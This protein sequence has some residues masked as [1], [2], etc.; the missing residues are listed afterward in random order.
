MYP[1]KSTFRWD[2]SDYAKHSQGQY[3][4][5]MGNIGKLAL[6]GSESVLDI[7]CGDGKI[8]AEIAKRVP[9]G[10]VL[11]I[12]LSQEMIAL[13]A[14]LIQLPHVRFQVLDA[15]ELHFDSEFDAVFSNSALHWMPDHAAVV[16]GMAR[17][18]KPGGRI[19][20]S[21]GGRGTAAS[22][23]KALDAMARD[24]RWSMFLAGGE[25]PF[26]FPGPEEYEPWLANAG[27]RA[28]RI[29]LV[30]KP[31]RHA[32]AAALEGWFRTT[33]MAYSGRVPE[34]QRAEFVRELADRARQDCTI[35]E[36]GALLMPMVNLEV[37]AHKESS[38]VA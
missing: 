25:S 27:I 4:W 5:A 35:A 10:R 34:N 31:M 13:A 6:Q 11:G 38:S 29:E 20:L 1:P 14:R 37:E 17:A 22:G 12:D 33:W 8:T 36:D 2:A 30:P 19:F 3:G 16:R 15:Q 32:D 26:H 9:H 24:P 28:D 18:L 21:M 7:G 23:F